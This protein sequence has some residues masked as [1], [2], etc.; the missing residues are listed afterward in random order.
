MKTYIYKKI[1]LEKSFLFMLKIIFQKK[2]FKI[3]QKILCTKSRG[4]GRSECVNYDRAKLIV[5]N[6]V[7]ASVN[8]H[9]ESS[10][11]SITFDYQK[12]N[13]ILEQPAHQSNADNVYKI[14]KYFF[15]TVILLV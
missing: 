7:K 10:C 9:L 8:A 5:L 6:A 2:N 12:I 14:N 11:R 1:S 13:E 15:S 3:R 4:G